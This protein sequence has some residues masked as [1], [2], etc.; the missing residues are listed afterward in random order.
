MPVGMENRRKLLY[1]FRKEAD[2]GSDGL[3]RII[4]DRQLP[5][6]LALRV[7]NVSASQCSSL[8]KRSES[9]E[10]TLVPV[11]LHLNLA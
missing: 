2:L 7:W 4:M 10:F 8:E 9:H 3:V 11:T 5:L 1:L 6:V